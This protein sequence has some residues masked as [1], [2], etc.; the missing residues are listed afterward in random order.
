MGST[1]GERNDTVEEILHCQRP[2]KAT[3]KL[4]HTR[5]FV[6]ATDEQKHKLQYSLRVQSTVK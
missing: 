3:C 2:T 6:S 4:A 5:L 1:K